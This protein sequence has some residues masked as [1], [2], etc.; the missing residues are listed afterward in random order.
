[1]THI[2]VDGTMI[3]LIVA[4]LV[5][6]LG[7]LNPKRS[8]KSGTTRVILSKDGTL[9]VRTGWKISVTLSRNGIEV[10]KRGMMENYTKNPKYI[11]TADN[12]RRRV[13]RFGD[14]GYG[15]RS[16]LLE[17]NGQGNI[18]PWH[19]V[20]PLITDLVVE[21]GVKYIGSEAFASCT[22]ITS[23]TI[24]NSVTDIGPNAFSGCYNLK[25]ITIPNRVKYILMGTFAGCTS[26]M[27][28]TIPNDVVAIG[29]YA[30]AGCTSLTSTT[31]GNMMTQIQPRVFDD[32]ISLM[33]VNVDKNNPTYSSINGVLFNNTKDTLILYPRG[34]QG[35]YTIP[36]SVTLIGTE[37]FSK[38]TNL[39]SV[40]MDYGVMAINYDA[41]YECTNLM[42]II[43]SNTM[44]TI[45]SD[46]FRGCIS[47]TSIVLPQS[48]TT[49]EKRAFYGCTNLISISSL[50]H[51]PPDVEHGAFKDISLNACLYVSVGSINAYRVANE[52]KEFKCIKTI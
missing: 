2:K 6:T 12:H 34:K 45:R 28:I 31:I 3:L 39:T 15:D 20:I 14:V 40:T 8:W 35:A 10:I 51:V 48:I 29:S 52:W 23:A 19:G 21:K 49:I 37:A 47:L 30:F 27:S 9:R 1:M 17:H 4:M 50:S 42:S 25:S 32:C 5:L 36:N 16:E 11:E 46:A 18:P 43:M 38:C 41:F 22:S 13:D 44:T 7:V 26:L 24:S 33:Y